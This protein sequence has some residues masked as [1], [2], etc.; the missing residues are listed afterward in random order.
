MENLV[1]TAISQ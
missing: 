1:K